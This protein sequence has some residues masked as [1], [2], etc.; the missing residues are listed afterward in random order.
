M[1]T[2]FSNS[3]CIQ[4]MFAVAKAEYHSFPISFTSVYNVVVGD[5]RSNRLVGHD[6][7][8]LSTTKCFINCYGNGSSST[9]Q[10]NVHVLAIGKKT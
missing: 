3:L 6:K 1:F 5:A 9:S 10:T 4:W 2:I 8:K 7:E